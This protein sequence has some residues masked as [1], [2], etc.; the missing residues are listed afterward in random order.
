M[1]RI[2][3]FVHS[4]QSELRIWKSY[5]L[6]LDIS[7]YVR[8]DEDRLDDHGSFGELTKCSLH[9]ISVM[10]TA[11]RWSPSSTISE[12][13]F[14][15]ADVNGRS[16][17]HCRIESYNRK[18]L[19]FRT[20]STHHKVPAFRAFDWSPHDEAIVAVGQWSGEATVLRIDNNSRSL[21]LPIKH[22]RLCN[23]VTFSKTGLLATGLERVR[24][25]FCLNIWDISQRL[26]NN[27]SSG[28]GSGRQY[29]EPIRKLASSEAITSIKFFHDQPDVLLCGVKGACLR[30]YDIRESTGSPSLQFQTSCVHNIAIDPLDENYFASA[31]PP[32]DLTVHIW[33][34]RLAP[35][36][37]ASSLGSGSS[38]NYQNGPIIEY[39]RA[40]DT[41]NSSN[42]PNIW[43]LRYC[44]GQSGYLGALASNGNYKIFETKKEYFPENAHSKVDHNVNMDCQILSAQ[45]LITKRV[46]QVEYAFD[47]AKSALS[48]KER[49]VSFDF[50]NLAGAGGMPCAIILR[51]DQTIDIYEMKGPSAVMSISALG[52]LAVSRN[53]DKTGVSLPNHANMDSLVSLTYPREGITAAS[54]IKTLRV[55]LNTAPS[56][57][58]LRPKV[59]RQQHERNRLGG[60]EAEHLSRKA[61]EALYDYQAADRKPD[62]KYA[63]E[64]LTLSRRRCVEGYLF[65]CGKNEGIVSDDPWLQGLWAWIG[66]RL[67]Q[68]RLVKLT[69]NLD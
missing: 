12:Q 3:E 20:L 64:F 10:E 31:G 2:N 61:H 69:V 43:S 29:L 67:G 56:I 59:P 9:T 58:E 21:S 19:R 47:D 16:F 52:S 27:T 1:F 32:K 49:I 44:K 41:S 46:H 7:S 6:G 68:S 54:T 65:D 55:K 14:L 63:L 4:L 8:L 17:R 28:P 38:H 51:R 39:K 5:F 62:I 37:S 42:Q 22:Q 18:I 36:S 53:L 60:L 45:Q 30:I 57:T 50:T 13:R 48:D 24:N 25:D 34:R 23:A 35:Q 40:F 11:I 15:V 33:D 26:S 66:R